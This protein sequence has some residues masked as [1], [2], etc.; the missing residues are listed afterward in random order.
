M[1]FVGP[2][3]SM[4]LSFSPPK[5][6]CKFHLFNE[7]LDTNLF[8]VLAPTLSQSA[9]HKS[10]N[11]MLQIRLIRTLGAGCIYFKR[12]KIAGDSGFILSP[13]L[14]IFLHERQVLGSTYSDRI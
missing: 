14:I 6:L 1:A 4:P 10:A 11:Q 12:R 3:L 2:H 5:C 9:S 8:T 7:S 13:C